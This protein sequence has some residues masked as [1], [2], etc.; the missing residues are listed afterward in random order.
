MSLDI[1]ELASALEK[2]MQKVQS[3][4]TEFSTILQAAETATIQA[5]ARYNNQMGALMSASSMAAA[6]SRSAAAI[7]NGKAA[8]YARLAASNQQANIEMLTKGIQ[9]AYDGQIQSIKAGVLFGEK[10]LNTEAKKATGLNSYLD[11]FTKVEQLRGSANQDYLRSNVDQAQEWVIDPSKLPE[12]FNLAEVKKALRDEELADLALQA[13]RNANTKAL[14]D[15]SESAL[16]RAEKATAF[17]LPKASSRVLNVMRKQADPDT[18]MFIGQEGSALAGV[19]VSKLAIN[20]ELQ[21][22]Q[23]EVYRQ[24]SASAAAVFQASETDNELGA[25]GSIVSR[26]AGQGFDLLTTPEISEATGNQIPLSHINADALP[27][28]NIR[29]KFKSLQQKL[30]VQQELVDSSALTLADITN[31]PLTPSQVK[32]LENTPLG[33]AIDRQVKKEAQELNTALIDNYV[34]SFAKKLQPAARQYIQFGKVDASEVPNVLFEEV[35][36]VIP[37][38]NNK[39]FAAGIAEVQKAM[40][41]ITLDKLNGARPKTAEE[42]LEDTEGM[43]VAEFKA[44]LQQEIAGGKAS[45]AQQLRQAEEEVLSSTGSTVQVHILQAIE[46]DLWGEALRQLEIERPDVW[47]GL[48]SSTTG[49]SEKAGVTMGADGNIQWQASEF[50]KEIWRRTNTLRKNDTSIP[51]TQLIDEFVAT[52][53]NKLPDFLKQAMKVESPGGSSVVQR[54]LGSYEQAAKQLYVMSVGQIGIAY[55][56]TKADVLQGTPRAAAGDL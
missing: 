27:D 7:P 41:N 55:E 29:G 5:N 31:E 11:A 19:T 14:V 42:I 30:L 23:E 56:Q 26:F 15:N 50:Y 38:T 3:S 22:R 46:L 54:Y 37:S 47:G 1:E 53:E 21:A 24:A 25:L 34:G 48:T 6:K 2:Q 12:R 33:I 8:K 9:T 10:R 17:W 45:K 35:N 28:A 52:I 36:G 20:K 32:E 44:F 51:A 43:N 4:G 40:G 18:G 39:Y 13:A 16:A 49:M